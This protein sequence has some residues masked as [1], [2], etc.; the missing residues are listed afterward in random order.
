MKLL[1]AVYFCLSF[2]FS[3]VGLA[4]S[5]NF[6]EESAADQLPQL[7]V[8][9]SAP[10]ALKP[11]IGFAIDKSS[12]ERRW[13]V[14][15]GFLSGSLAWA[16]S[17]FSTVWLIVASTL[18]AV[19]DAAGDAVM[20]SVAKENDRIQ[21]L[22]IAARAVGD[23]VG[24]LLGGVAYTFFGY[25][26]TMRATALCLVPLGVASLDLPK[27]ERQCTLP[28]WTWTLAHLQTV[29]FLLVA[30]PSPSTYILLSWQVAMTP[31]AIAAA[32]VATQI[33]TLAGLWAGKAMR[34]DVSIWGSAVC[35]MAVTLSS[36]AT[37]L[38]PLPFAVGQNL[39]TGFGYALFLAPYIETVTRLIPAEN[40][41]F[42]YA[43]MMAVINMGGMASSEIESALMKDSGLEGPKDNPAVLV[44]VSLLLTLSA[45]PL[46]TC[47]Q[48]IS[49]RARGISTHAH[50]RNEL[51]PLQ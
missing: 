5:L 45:F 51:V 13:F 43:C 41:A 33:G 7:Y 34:A 29:G 14:C 38:A 39:L 49:A 15:G 10:W 16:L 24:T 50:G 36:T 47:F 44:C 2:C 40:T 6:L 4:I 20:V 25:A 30:T 26:F 32:S 1:L 3:F 35:G 46:G 19:A 9:V 8:A 48:S 23:V 31:I 27:A 21:R 37:A 11:I 12:L 18:I 28:K 22:S 42:S 17:P